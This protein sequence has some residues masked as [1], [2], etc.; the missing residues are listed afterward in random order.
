MK[1]HE[2]ILQEL[3]QTIVKYDIKSHNVFL[4]RD[5]R[6]LYNFLIHKFQSF[7][8]NRC[9]GASLYN[10]GLNAISYFVSFNFELERCFRIKLR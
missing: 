6:A 1:Y 4:S 10:K 5:L 9:S 7:M 8:W 2:L 3:Y